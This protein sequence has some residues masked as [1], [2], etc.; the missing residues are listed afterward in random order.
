MTNVRRSEIKSKSS[1]PGSAEAVLLW[2][3]VFLMP[4]QLRHTFL[5]AAIGGEYFEYGSWH[6]YASDIAIILLL[7]VWLLR[8]KNKKIDIG[9]KVLSWPLLAFLVWSGVSV[10]WAIDRPVALIAEAHLWLFF[11]FYLYLI[12][13]VKDTT[14]ILWPL[15]WGIALQAAW[16]VAQ[17][18]ANSSLGLSWLGESVLNPQQVGVPVIEL[19]GFRQ[20]RA[21]GMLPHA[22]VLGGW[23]VAAFPPLLYWFAI[24]KNSIIK[25]MIVAA[26][27]LV[28]MGVALS[29]A[30][31]AWL[32]FVLSLIGI[33]LFWAFG[34]FKR[35]L[36]IVVG[37]GLMFLLVLLTQYR[38][39]SSRFDLNN[40]LEEISI[41]ERLASISTWRDVF[42]KNAVRG[43]G[44][45]NYTLAMQQ[46][47]P[48]QPSWWYQPVHNIYL[49]IA[50]E[51]GVVGLAIWLWLVGA[52]LLIEYWIWRHN[53]TLA[54][55][56][57]PINS[58]LL[59]GLMD[60]W[61]IALQQG[62]LLIFFALALIILGYRL[63]LKENRT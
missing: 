4:W 58:L 48:N 31:G 52:V 33:G 39:V 60:H 26:L 12:N 5:F 40:R 17:F 46:I 42:E 3:S 44:L 45:G 21:H 30:R 19:N 23:L 13:E 53:R 7:A 36:W 27:G 56:S 20:L 28:A 38:Y 49:V 43:A 15:L 14:R 51:L 16:G 11:G 50:G 1:W 59:L 54:V 8:A 47:E 61:P 22:N 2:L 62:K 57:V 9:P 34:G 32:V 37:I 18:V 63:S 10:L 6:L 55:M 35:K 29:F 41:E 24:N 25:R